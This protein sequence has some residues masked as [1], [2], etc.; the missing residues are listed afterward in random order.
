MGVVNVGVVL[1]TAN[2][3]GCETLVTGATVAVGLEGL[4]LVE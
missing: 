3:R 1:G 2:G 4:G